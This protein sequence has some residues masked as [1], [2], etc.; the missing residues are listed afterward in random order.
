MFSLLQATG[1]GSRDALAA[2]EVASLHRELVRANGMLGL[3]DPP[4]DISA[5]RAWIAEARSTVQGERVDPVDLQ[6]PV[7]HEADRLVRERL[8][9]A[10]VLVPF[11]VKSL[12]L[13]GIGT[14]EIPEGLL[15]NRYH[16]ALAPPV[17]SAS[18]GDGDE[19][20]AD[21]T[22]ASAARSGAGSALSVRRIGEAGDLL[23]ARESRHCVTHRR[24]F[25][26]YFAALVTAP[27]LLA[28]PVVIAGSG[29]IILKQMRPE[30]FAWVP[31]WLIWF[32]AGLV[33]LVLPWI[34]FAVPVRCVMCLQ[35]HF[36]PSSRSYHQQAHHIVG[37]GRVLPLCLSILFRLRYRCGHCATRLALRKPRQS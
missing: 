27:L 16:G 12:A 30:P 25:R 4:P 31:S 24:P 20:S 10:P 19:S 11:S 23:P 1:H 26:I 37:L 35:R 29:L 3:V 7:D 21:G 32:S 33:L 17:R 15:L 2:A 36:V 13:Q 14:D 28:L 8:A 34:F 22:R 18:E 9:G 6:A 5:L